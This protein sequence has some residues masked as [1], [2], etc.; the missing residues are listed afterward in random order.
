MTL[1]ELTE[2]LPIL[3][4]GTFAIGFILF[5]LALS[6]FRRSRRASYWVRR[7]KAGRRGFRVLILSIV[8]F[9]LSIALCIVAVLFATLEADEDD[10]TSTPAIVEAPNTATTQPATQTPSETPTAE[11]TVTPTIMPTVTDTIPPDELPTEEVTDI[12]ITPS[13]TRQPSEVSAVDEQT[14][15]SPTP[16]LTPTIT[17]TVRPSETGSPSAT[18]TSS[19]TLTAT[20]SLTPTASPTLT[21]TPSLTATASLTLTPTPTVPTATPSPTPFPT[22][23]LQIGGPT[24]WRTP[25]D[26]AALNITAIAIDIDDEWG[27]VNSANTFS[28][29]TTRLYFFIDFMGMSTGV[30]WQWVLFKDGEYIDGRTLLWGNQAHGQ[31]IFFYGQA[32][33]F[34]PGEYEIWMFVGEEMPGEPAAQF[35]ITEP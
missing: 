25:R 33:G 5:L 27:P 7:R 23:A 20:S 17:I 11:S 10:T 34:I 26:D 35:T 24:P 1:D 4:A 9:S 12:P 8:F 3:T 29:D 14:T 31:T 16:T 13:V 22:L 30:E 32:M 15:D 21:M 6:L 19:P 2:R 18:S 28:A